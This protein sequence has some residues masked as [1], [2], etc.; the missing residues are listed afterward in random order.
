MRPARSP[1]EAM[2]TPSDPA[3]LQGK[4]NQKER[5]APARC[6]PVRAFGCMRA[7]R[8]RG[9]ASFPDRG[10]SPAVFPLPESGSAAGL[11]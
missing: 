7:G 2:G 6:V 5:A 1:G 3:P 10:R 4:R 11:S 9:D 8:L